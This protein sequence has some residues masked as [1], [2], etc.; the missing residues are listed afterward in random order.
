MAEKISSLF[1]A[2]PRP[3]TR[4][5]RRGRGIITERD[6][7]RAIA[8]HGA[9]A[10]DLAGRTASRAR[11]SRRFPRT[12]SSIAPW[13]HEP[14]EDPPSRRRGRDG[15]GGRRAVGARSAAAARA[16]RGD[17]SATRSSS[18]DDVQRSRAGLGAKLPQVAA[19][20]LAE[21][22]SG[23]RHR[24]GHLARIGRADAPRGHARGAPHAD[25]GDG[26]AA[27]RLRVR[28][29]RLGRARRKPARDG[30]GQRADL[31]RGRAGRRGGPLVRETRHARRRHPG[32]SRRA[33]LQGRRDG[34]EP[35]MARLA[36]D[37]AGAHR[38]NGSGARS[39]R[40]C[41]RS[42]SSS[43]CA[44]CT[45]TPRWPRRCGAEPST[46]R[47]GRPAFSK[48]LA[49]SAGGAQS[50]LGFFGGIKDRPG[51]HRPQEDGH[52]RH[53]HLPRACSRSAT[54]SSSAR[55]RR[56]SPAWALDIGGERD[57]DALREAER[58]VPRS[59][60]R[61]AGRRHRGRHRPPTRS[62]SSGSRGATA[63]GCGPR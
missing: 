42:T 46:R 40:T 45:A 62:R 18:A 8:A 22:V 23:A 44:A 55:R 50:G 7:L 13:P 20:L 11:R 24:R 54:T 31:R 34:E 59:H 63:S 56:G 35:A 58:A 26:R 10:L 4:G 27:L 2:A 12:T 60:P 51:P 52:L 33:A 30:S 9:A 16:G 29:A 39:R 57:L 14:A 53:R 21:D 25:A 3:V 1:V 61:P 5:R 36:R 32:R 28:G 48:L 19:A 41:S 17:R 43:T 15:R 38:A 49:E 37:L 6:V 47:T